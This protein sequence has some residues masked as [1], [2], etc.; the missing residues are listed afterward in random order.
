MLLGPATV[1]AVPEWPVMETP[2]FVA[3]SKDMLVV[4]CI[5]PDVL[6]GGTSPAAV[7]T[8]R[9]AFHLLTLCGGYTCHEIAE[10]CEVDPVTVSGGIRAFRRRKEER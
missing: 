5:N 10:V 3:K 2:T 1:E 9:H 4:R 6:G 7:V 8:R